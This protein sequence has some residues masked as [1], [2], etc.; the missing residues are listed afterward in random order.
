MYKIAA[1][2]HR[3]HMIISA[4]RVAS[5]SAGEIPITHIGGIRPNSMP[6]R[7]LLGYRWVAIILSGNY[8][9]NCHTQ[10]QKIRANENALSLDAS[11]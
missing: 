9:Y 10:A 11:D 1:S 3:M 4:Y 6:P 7:P 2:C 5:D 8:G